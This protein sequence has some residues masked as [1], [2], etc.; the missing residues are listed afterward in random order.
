[1]SLH[2]VTNGGLLAE[3]QHSDGATHHIAAIAFSGA[4]EVC[5]LAS[6]KGCTVCATPWLRKQGAVLS[7]Y[8]CPE[9]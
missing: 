7:Q 9:V 4:K 2:S 8:T 5:A 3:W 1:M 6:A